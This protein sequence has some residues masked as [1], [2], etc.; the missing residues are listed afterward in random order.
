MVG[1]KGIGGLPDPKSERTTSKTRNDKDNTSRDVSAGKS[2]GG[3]KDD[4]N[5]SSEAR[6]AVEAGRIIQ[7]ARAQADIRADR[8]EAARQR[9]EEGLY[10]NPDVVRQV[11]EKIAKIIE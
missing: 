8:I 9:L 10:R 11:A 6:V 5:I 4:L 3:G 2:V 1:I 7:A